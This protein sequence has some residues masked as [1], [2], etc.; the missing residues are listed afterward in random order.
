MSKKEKITLAT[1]GGILLALILVYV[2]AVAPML[3]EETKTSPPEVYPG[4]GL[5]LGSAI[6]LFPEVKADKV[7]SIDVK[8]E[9]GEYGFYVTKDENGKSKT[10]IKGHEKLEYDMTVYA[11]LLAYARLPVVPM[12]TNIYRDVEDLSVYGLTPETCK[13]EITVKFTGSD[14]KEETQVII[15]GNKIIAYENIYYA[16]I[17]GRNHVYTMNGAGVE[18][19]MLKPLASYVSP[20]IYKNFDSASKALLHIENFGMFLTTKVEGETAKD[21]LILSHDPQQPSD[22]T[23]Q[24]VLTCPKIY[25][26]GVVASTSYIVEAFNTLYTTFQGKEVVAII[27][28]S[29]SLEEID[30]IL[31]DY[32]LATGQEQYMLYAKG[33]KDDADII[34][35]YISKEIEGYHYVLS[36]YHAE[37]TVVKVAKENLTFLGEGE[38]TALKWTATNSVLAGFNSYLSPQPEI[39]E[40]GVSTIKIYT[41]GNF[42][43][44]GGYDYTFNV[45]TASGKLYISSTDGTQVFDISKGG[46][47]MLFTTLYTVLVSMPKPTQFTNKTESEIA[48]IIKSENLIYQL[49]VKLND[50]KR[51]KDESGNEIGEAYGNT[52]MRYSYYLIDAGYSLCVSEIGSVDKDGNFVY[53]ESR[54]EMIFEVSTRHI[55]SL[56]EAYEKTLNRVDF[57]ANDY[58]S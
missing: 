6:S 23:V 18:S 15:I 51:D 30:E 53:D 50:S 19:A 25:P 31:K 58:I 57:K 11:Y 39:G 20:V 36:E 8:N 43:S 35:M 28:S 33:I 12:D 45:S 22:T 1:L 34:T 16:T 29:Q 21:V 13:A 48:E 42:A 27:S 41:V 4:E 47:N 2:L 3:Y 37:R 38:E 5:Y 32:G 54:T 56:A 7:I 14:G 49:E 26:Q 17:K 55:F 46:D 10:V 40:P 44:I 24:F 9:S 52:V